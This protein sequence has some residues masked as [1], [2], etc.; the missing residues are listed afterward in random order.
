MSIK[1]IQTKGRSGPRSISERQNTSER[2]RA[3][4]SCVVP[5]LKKFSWEKN[6]DSND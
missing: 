3:K 6:N 2:N 4:A 5:P 1:I